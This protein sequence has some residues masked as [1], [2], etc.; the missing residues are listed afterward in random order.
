[1]TVDEYKAVL[2]QLKSNP[3]AV[4]LIASKLEAE[5]EADF[6][7]ITKLQEQITEQE[8]KIKDMGYQLWLTTTSKPDDTSHKEDEDEGSYDDLIAAIR[9]ENKE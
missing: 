2:G 4:E 7:N 5:I 3:E 6:G 8:N 9:E 1:M